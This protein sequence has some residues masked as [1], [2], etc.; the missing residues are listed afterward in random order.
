[1]REALEELLAVLDA[2]YP[3]GQSKQVPGLTLYAAMEKARE[4]L[5]DE[6]AP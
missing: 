6:S 4:A 3:K 5:N 1:M 2:R